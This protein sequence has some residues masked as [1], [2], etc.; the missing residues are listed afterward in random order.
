MS[1]HYSP[2]LVPPAAISW[3]WAGIGADVMLSSLHEAMV[4]F[5]T[6]IG[7]VTKSPAR[8]AEATESTAVR[9]KNRA[10]HGGISL[11]AYDARL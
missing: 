9:A 6:N 7:G 10:N 11:N 4:L 2:G 5:P 3:N 8:L 1:G